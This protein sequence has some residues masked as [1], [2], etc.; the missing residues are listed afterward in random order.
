[1]RSPPGNAKHPRQRAL[2]SALVAL[3]V[4]AQLVGLA[5]LA[6]VQHTVCW[7][8]GDLVDLPGAGA[9]SAVGSAPRARPA[10]PGLGARASAIESPQHRHC[11]ALARRED[12]ALPPRAE[13][14]LVR[15]EL[16]AGPL[17]PIAAVEGA[18]AALLRLAPK[19]SPPSLP[20]V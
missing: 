17:A 4:G 8:D 12:S 3:L 13:L 18:P 2:N 1:M 20:L 10:L 7:E 5:H 9:S 11:D 14:R 15:V 16:P 6:L 19:Q